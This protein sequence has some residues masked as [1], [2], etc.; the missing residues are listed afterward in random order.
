[1]IIKFIIKEFLLCLTVLFA[2]LD[3]AFFSAIVEGNFIMA[4]PLIMSVAA[5]RISYG[6]SEML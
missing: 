5:T 2:F 1:M 6:A 4:L 3:F